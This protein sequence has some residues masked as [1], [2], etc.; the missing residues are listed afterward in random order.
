MSELSALQWSQLSAAL[1]QVAKRY[2]PRGSQQEGFAEGL[3]E[4]AQVSIQHEAM[5][6]AEKKAK[7][8]AKGGALGSIGSVLGTAAGIALAPATGGASLALAG[9]LGGAIGGAAGTA[10]GGGS[11]T[12]E[13]TAMQGLSGAMTGYG[14][15]KA[16]PKTSAVGAQPPGPF[17][18]GATATPPASRFLP[19][20]AAT[21]TLPFGK[22]FMGALTP[23]MQTQSALASLTGSLPQGAGS[24]VPDSYNALP[25]ATTPL[26]INNGQLIKDPYTGVYMF[27]PRRYSG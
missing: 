11:P 20:A 10:L 4:N 22:R 12:L 1:A 18:P 2:S 14:A 8:K 3:L 27:N 26:R 13:G 23:A 9:G 19:A 16:M 15:G 21:A 7:K 17:V 24:S 5:K 25:K 6:E